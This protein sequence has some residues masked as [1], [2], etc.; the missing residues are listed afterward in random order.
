MHPALLLLVVILVSCQSAAPRREARP[1]QEPAQ[2]EKKSEAEFFDFKELEK[3]RAESKRSYL[4]FLRSP[5]LHCGV[6]SLAKGS[7]DGQRPH[8]E[9][10]VYY[11]V[12]GRSQFTAGEQTQAVQ[13]GSVIFVAKEVEHRFHD[14]E[15]DL[16]ILVFF[17]TKK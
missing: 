6:Y 17:S 15:E 13:P 4:P 16:E 3:Q 1:E 2:D 12:S 5:A 11:V 14:I 9:D 8:D 10:E 7:T